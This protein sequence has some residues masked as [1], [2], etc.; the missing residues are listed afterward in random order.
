MLLQNDMSMDIETK[1]LLTNLD[2]NSKIGGTNP[3][4]ELSSDFPVS[5]NT[6]LSGDDK[7]MQA[8]KDGD[9]DTCQKMVNEA[10]MS[11]GYTIQAWHGTRSEEKFTAFHD[12]HENKQSKAPDGTYFF[13]GDRDVAF[14]YAG[15]SDNIFKV[16]LKIDNPFY[17]DF[18]GSDWQGDLYGKFEADNDGETKYFE[19][20]NLA[21]DW[22]VEN[23]VEEPNEYIRQDPWV[24][25]TTNSAVLEAK[26][27]GCDGAVMDNV[28][29]NGSYSDPSAG[30]VYV[31]FSPNQIKSAELVTHDDSGNIIP[32]SQRFNESNND[33]RFEKTSPIITTAGFDIVVKTSSE[34]SNEIINEKLS[35]MSKRWEADGVSSF[36][37]ASGGDI[38]LSEIRMD[39]SQRGRGI[40][41]SKMNELISFAQENNMRITLTPSIDFGATSKG[42][43]ERFYSGLGFTRNRGRNKDYRTM[44][45]MIWR[46]VA[47]DHVGKTSHERFDIVVKTSSFDKSDKNSNEKISS[48]FHVSV[49]N[50][51]SGI[52]IFKLA[53]DNTNKFKNDT[54]VFFDEAEQLGYSSIEDLYRG[55]QNGELLVNSR[56][57]DKSSSENLRYGL[58]PEFGETLQDTEAA[59]TAYEYGITPAELVFASDNFGWVGGSRNAAIF[60][61]KDGFQKSLGNNKVE[62]SNGQIVNYEMSPVADFED[63]ALKGE[64]VGVETGDWYSKDVATVVAILFIN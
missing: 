9:I 40:G 57:F 21:H 4:N 18:Q 33:I 17:L 39:K 45:S 61:T 23:G 1:S 41:T 7:Y 46:P 22:L 42:R 50:Q 2:A 37:Y 20:W 19:N 52:K 24:G 54:V 44:D 63:P 36:A 51:L 34:N 27:E 60:L 5:V 10:A 48:N 58:Y 29:D 16:F 15:N 25:Y 47:T 56:R 3:N 64:P 13:S 6:Q 43:L 11:A 59:M 53:Q 26:Q 35:E 30:T 31:V 28:I 38:K 62:L 32:L 55:V 49:F 8:A 14:S 12:N